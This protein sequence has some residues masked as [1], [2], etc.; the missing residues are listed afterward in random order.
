ME[1]FPLFFSANKLE[2]KCFEAPMEHYGDKLNL[3]N[4]RNVACS[5][6]IYI[7]ILE[8]IQAWQTASL[9]IDEWESSDL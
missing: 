7:I 1:Q 3:C 9:G 6:M 2:I 8:V 4:R 5:S